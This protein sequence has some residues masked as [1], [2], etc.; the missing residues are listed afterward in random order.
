MTF[1]FTTTQRKMLSI[2]AQREDR[3]LEPT[4][5][6]KGAVAKVFGSKL[7]EAGFAREIKA[8][9]RLPVWRYDK[10]SNQNSVLKLTVLGVKIAT[11]QSLIAEQPPGPEPTNLSQSLR[12]TSK[13]SQVIV[14][15]ARED[16]VTIGYIS[17]EMGWLPHTTRATL[18]GLRKRGLN[19]VRQSM[20][21]QKSSIYRI[22]SSQFK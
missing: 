21:G 2:A 14:L 15:L 22:A 11:E 4:A 10:E 20:E 16:G 18:T 6:L 1:K 12:K 9:P 3:C 5:E 19:I 7:I 13:L 8:R 17:N